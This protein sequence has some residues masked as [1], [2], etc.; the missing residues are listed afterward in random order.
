MKNEIKTVLNKLSSNEKPLKKSEIKATQLVNT[1]RDRRS[2]MYFPNAS[3]R[4]DQGSMNQMYPRTYAEHMIQFGNPANE[5]II[6][7]EN[8][9]N[10]TTDNFINLYN[11]DTR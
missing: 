4:N 9:R 8:E 1:Q 11:M 3:Q 10:N 2:T 7:Q 6:V 5:N